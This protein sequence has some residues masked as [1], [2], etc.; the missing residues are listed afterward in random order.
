VKRG[1]QAPSL[2]L[3][4]RSPRYFTTK[5]VVP[6]FRHLLYSTVSGREFCQERFLEGATDEAKMLV[7][8]SNRLLWEPEIGDQVKAWTLENWAHFE[9]EAW[10]NAKVKARVP[11]EYIP[12][13]AL[14]Q[15]GG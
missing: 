13:A 10:F 2:T 1:L 5:V 9:G 3:H 14:Q 4:S 12:A 7:F 8:R 6:K 11:K 15:M